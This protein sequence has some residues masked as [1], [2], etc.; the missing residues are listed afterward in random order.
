MLFIAGAIYFPSSDPN[1]SSIQMML[2]DAINRKV[3]GGFYI[4]DAITNSPVPNSSIVI[5][6]HNDNDLDGNKDK[7]VLDKKTEVDNWLHFENLEPNISIAKYQE[8]NRYIV[9]AKDN[10]NP[11]KIGGCYMILSEPGHYDG[12]TI[13]IKEDGRLDNLQH[14]NY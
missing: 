5:K 11:E 8:S 14:C 1:K 13:K 12:W 6:L 3:S 9:I 10:N 2:E 7:V 4:V